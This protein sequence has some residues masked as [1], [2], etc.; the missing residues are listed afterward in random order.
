MNRLLER[1][2]Y[3]YGW[4]TRCRNL[5]PARLLRPWLAR[6]PAGQDGS[7]LDVGCGRLGLAAYLPEY[8]VVGVDIEPPAETRPNFSFRSASI[9]DLPFGDRSF[10]V[11]SCVDVLEHLPL[12]VR[13]R[14]IRQLVRVAS[15]AVL[16]AAP[17]GENGYAADSEFQRALAARGRE[18]PSWL[19]EHQRQPYPTVDAVLEL[20]AAEAATTGRRAQFS[21]SY[22]EPLGACRTVRA[23]AVHSGPI[24][25]AANLVLGAML[26]ILPVPHAE[27]SYRMVIVAE[28]T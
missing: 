22:C 21:V 4:D 2:L 8:R 10:P 5:M 19:R 15:H 18:I 17:H 14:S 3:R 6:L 24:Y 12:D 27:N 25:V 28:L 11:V 20:V 13:E 26:P 23:A 1:T 9:T 16:I 7:L